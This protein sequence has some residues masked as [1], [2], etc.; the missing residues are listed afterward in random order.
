MADLMETDVVSTDAGKS[1]ADVGTKLYEAG[2]G[3]VIARSGKGVPIGILT[4]QDLLRAI[5]EA[6]R[7]LTDIPA[8]E[9]M[10]RPLLTIESDRPV[11][12]AVRQMNEADVEQ[13]AIV[14][15][16]DVVGII[17][18]K[19]VLA[20]YESLIKAAHAAERRRI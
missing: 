19:D 17:S 10:S 11:R 13:L 16:F 8:E 14:T 3:S 9:Y 4:P 6:D 12:S 15:E 7:P 2:V 18:Q 1:L 5:A 20:A